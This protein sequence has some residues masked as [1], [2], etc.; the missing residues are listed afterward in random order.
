MKQTLK[1]ILSVI[2]DN[3]KFAEGKHSII[4]ALNGAIIV[5]CINFFS[6]QNLLILILNYGVIFF[7]GAS[8][9]IS[10][11]ALLSRSI[12]LKGKKPRKE[13]INLLYFKDLSH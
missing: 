7:C 2:M 1:Y 11:M 8:I 9:I 12:K 3:L 4:I 6:S 5:L 13:N 10:A